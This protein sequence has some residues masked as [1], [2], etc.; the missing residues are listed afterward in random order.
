MKIN[1]LVFGSL[2]DVTG[3][4]ALHIQAEGITSTGTL[5]QYLQTNYPGLQHKSYQLAV[6]QQLAIAGQAL[7]EGDEIAL[8]PPFSGG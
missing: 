3:T 8:L 5:Q 7:N 6:N 4:S 2:A 1:I